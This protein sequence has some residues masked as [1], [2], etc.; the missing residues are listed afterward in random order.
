MVLAV[1]PPAG[2]QGLPTPKGERR[3]PPHQACRETHA[4]T[5]R[6]GEFPSGKARTNQGLKALCKKLQALGGHCEVPGTR[7]L[8]L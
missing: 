2:K 6:V 1:R 4:S 7:V 5:Y 8:N 3:R